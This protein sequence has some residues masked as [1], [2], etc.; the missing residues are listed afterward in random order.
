MLAGNHH[1]PFSH[2][3][4][5]LQRVLQIQKDEEIAKALQLEEEQRYY[6]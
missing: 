3:A 2:T 4:Q 5:E 6:F 1:Q